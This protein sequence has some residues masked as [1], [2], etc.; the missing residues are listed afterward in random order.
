MRR[1][2][3][4]PECCAGLPAPRWSGQ[5]AKDQEKIWTSV[6][7]SLFV[8]NLSGTQYI[9]DAHP[10]LEYSSRT[11]MGHSSQ[12]DLILIYYPRHTSAS[13]LEHQRHQT[14]VK[15]KYAQAEFRAETFLKF[16]SMLLLHYITYPLVSCLCAY[17]DGKGCQRSKLA[18]KTGQIDVMI[19]L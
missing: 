11:H 6:T 1:V 2:K 5:I 10:E 17:R 15:I 3:H 7:V 9:K 12:V 4:W 13:F 18:L 8:W 14:Q 19:Q 16:F